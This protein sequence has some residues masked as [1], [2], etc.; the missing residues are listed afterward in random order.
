MSEKTPDFELNCG[1]SDLLKVD[2]GEELLVIQ[3]GSLRV[4]INKKNWKM[5]F[6]RGNEKIT[7]TAWRDLA[8]VKT[9]WRGLAYDDGGEHDTYIRERLSLSVGELIYGLGE[10]FTPFVKNGQSVD[11]WNEDGGTSTE[12][13]YKN[14]PF[15]SPIK[16]MAYL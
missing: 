14:I 1:K 6:Y 10:R 7:D 2:D 4:E 5:T 12:Q 8:Y 16:D 15:I 13:S 9:D 3:N 11:I